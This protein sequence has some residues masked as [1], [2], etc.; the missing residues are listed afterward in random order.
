MSDL[1]SNSMSREELIRAARANCVKRIEQPGMIKEQTGEEEVPV[2][3]PVSK[4]TYL[5]LFLAGLLFLGTFLLKYYNVSFG[6]LNSQTVQNVIESESDFIELQKDSGKLIEEKIIPV[7]H[8]LN[9]K[10]L[11]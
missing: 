9:E 2:H 5:R 8:R 7:F 6:V 4:G 1:S 11:L 3:T 10:S